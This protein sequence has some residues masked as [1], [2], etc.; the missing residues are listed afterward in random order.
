L[1][2]LVGSPLAWVVHLLAGY[3]VVALWCSAGWA[4]ADAVIGILTLVCAAA[5][6]GS[7][8][9]SFRLWRQGQ[10]ELVSGPEPGGPESWDARL[11]ERGARTVF[12]AVLALFMAA[13]FAYLILL[14]GLPPLFTPTCPATTM[15]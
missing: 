13:L 9:L 7:G 2:A 15:P 12:L 1:L 14:E 4:G 5:A 11:G 8:V 6:V 3:V 10:T